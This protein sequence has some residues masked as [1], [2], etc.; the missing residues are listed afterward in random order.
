M[1]S[2]GEH[3]D[4]EKETDKLKTHDIVFTRR[5]YK[6]ADAAKLRLKRELEK[7]LS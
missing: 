2:D 1:T 3:W 6:Q 4:L 5:I 7:R